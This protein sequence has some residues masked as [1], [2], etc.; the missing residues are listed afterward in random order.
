MEPK[1]QDFVAFASQRSP[2]SAQ[3]G[4]TAAPRHHPGS[5]PHLRIGSPV[6]SKRSAKAWRNIAKA[7]KNL[8]DVQ[9][10]TGK[11]AEALGSVRQSLKISED[12]LSKDP[13]QQQFQI[14]VHQ[15]RMLLIDILSQNG[16]TEEAR[17]ETVRALQFLK[18]LA[19]RRSFG[20]SD[21]RLCGTVGDHALHWSPGQRGSFKLW[22]KGG[23]HD[24]R[25]RS[26]GARRIGASVCEELRFR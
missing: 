3:D 18:P 8:A 25:K 26:H 1:A 23:R 11:L 20:V 22:T 2:Y 19:Q 10:I 13:R 5:H 12:H 17:A 4:D 9:Q 7:F 14:D 24:A 16:K 15:A 21:S 6:T